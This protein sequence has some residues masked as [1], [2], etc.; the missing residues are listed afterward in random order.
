MR[1]S[2]RTSGGRGEYELS[3]SHGEVTPTDV[4]GRRFFVAFDD[5]WSIDSGVTLTSQGGKRRLRLQDASIHLHRQIA[6]S[7]L[8]PSPVRADDALGSGRPI[9]MSDRYAIEH[10]EL[11]DVALQGPSRVTVRIGEITLRNY[12][13]HAEFLH[14]PGRVESVKQLWASA[15]KL[16]D[17]I[18]DLLRAHQS[19]VTAGTAVP[20]RGEQIVTALQ[21]RLSELGPDFRIYRQGGEDVV[22]D[23]LETLELAKVP[24]EPPLHVA[25]IDPSALELRRRTVREWRRWAAARGAASARFRQDV[26]IAYDWTCLVCGQRY[27]RTSLNR[28]AGVDAAHILPWAD[29]E[30]DRVANGLCLCKQHHWAFDEGL[31]VLAWDGE[32]YILEMPDAA[33]A[34]I[35]NECPTFGFTDLLKHTGPVAVE[36]LPA[37]IED[38]PD[39]Q[40]L[41]LYYELYHRS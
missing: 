25:E 26:R 30:L 38:R 16:P 15:D 21:D 37:R 7:L 4:V 10:I 8:M 9:L 35:R 12:N 17:E 33:V 40:L 11:S 39:P 36:R 41:A 31:L 20:L 19:L 5:D 3:E 1:I 2:R 23:L 32:K 27:P 18:A 29:Y 34:T 14:Y 22:P 13:L 6:A 28:M 24:P